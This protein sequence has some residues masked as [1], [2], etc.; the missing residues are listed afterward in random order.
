MTSIALDEELLSNI[1][2]LCEKHTADLKSKIVKLVGKHFA[3]T[4]KDK[5]R[6][7]KNVLKQ[8]PQKRERERE[9]RPL[10]QKLNSGTRVTN[11]KQRKEESSD[12]EASDYSD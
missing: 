12:E 10:P 1:E 9:S 2:L 3:K 4:I 5:D 8:L 7:T 6:Q 11:R